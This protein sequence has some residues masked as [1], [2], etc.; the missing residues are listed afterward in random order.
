[1]HQI[2]A[3]LRH[4]HRELYLFGP[5]I[6]P[7]VLGKYRM[8]CGFAISFLCA[9][10]AGLDLLA[11]RWLPAALWVISAGLLLAGLLAQSMLW[12]AR[13]GAELGGAA[14]AAALLSVLAAA[15][16]QVKAALRRS[17]RERRSYRHIPGTARALAAAADAN[18]PQPARRR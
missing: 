13:A 16:F 11:R 1:M 4:I 2:L 17:R 10:A 12:G 3:L 14:I 6:I 9:C 15:I 7:A 5:A 8:Q 18:R